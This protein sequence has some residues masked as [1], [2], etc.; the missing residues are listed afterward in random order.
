VT[1][2]R[3]P[4]R[5]RDPDEGVRPLASALLSA[6]GWALH[7]RRHRPLGTALLA[8]SLILVA[9]QRGRAKAQAASFRE[10]S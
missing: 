4:Q 7:S 6:S 8:A 5:L 10:R 3:S 1:H 9:R 2:V